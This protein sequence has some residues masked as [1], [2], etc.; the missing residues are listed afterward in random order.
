M[1]ASASQG[2]FGTVQSNVLSQSPTQTP[3]AA[4]TTGTA[5]ATAA[6]TTSAVAS[7]ALAATPA[8]PT[9][10][11]PYYFDAIPAAY[12]IM[13][14]L[15]PFVKEDGLVTISSIS[16]VAATKLKEA[17]INEWAKL[18]VTVLPGDIPP[19]PDLSL[20]K[21]G[22]FL[23][24]I[25]KGL[26]L[27]ALASRFRQYLQEVKD[28]YG[29]EAIESSYWVAVPDKVLEGTRGLPFAEQIEIMEDKSPGAQVAN[30]LG[31]CAAV[32]LFQERTGK[33]MLSDDPPTYTR[34]LQWIK[35]YQ[36]AVGCFSAEGLD[37]TFGTKP[38]WEDTDIALLP[39]RKL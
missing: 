28:A 29:E 16:V 26:K 36:T 31:I 20:L 3:E 15:A 11:S 7:T 8:L 39:L 10:T 19:V 2:N 37:V 38:H 25:P 24:L 23:V 32:L 12:D 34:T 9:R 30:I 18:G 33:R 4:A 5:V 21:P 27:N 22:E 14:V 13:K 17:I 1:D 6:A 35:G